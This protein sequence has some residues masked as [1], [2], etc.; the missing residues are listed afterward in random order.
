MKSVYVRINVRD[1]R[2]KPAMYSAILRP[3]AASVSRHMVWVGSNFCLTDTE[4]E[5]I[6]VAVKSFHLN[7]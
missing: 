2:L 1:C 3:I 7:R 6:F 4:I 5:K